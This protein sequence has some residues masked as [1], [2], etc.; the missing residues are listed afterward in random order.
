MPFAFFLLGERPGWRGLV[1]LV[2]ASLGVLAVIDPRAASFSSGNFSGNLLLLGAALTWALYSVLVAR[3]GGSGS[4]LLSS[5]LMLL[6]GLPSSLALG[7]LEIASTGIGPITGAIVAGV[8]FLGIVSTAVA[9]FL[10]N[11]AFARLPA[12]TAALTFFA[13]PVV[14][15]ALA[16]IFLGE[17]LTP[18]FLIGAG[19]IA[20]GLLLVKPRNAGD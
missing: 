7:S 12:G 5:A 14:G 13:Q 11:Y 4:I 19:L 1:A 20:A 2:V 3:I 16:V 10:W 6:G 8:L 18:L 15:T 9:M 17:V